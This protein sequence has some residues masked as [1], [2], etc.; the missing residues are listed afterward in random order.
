VASSSSQ[1]LTV[2]TSTNTLPSF[3]SLSINPANTLFN[4]LEHDIG[5]MTD[6]E[7]QALMRSTPPSGGSVHGSNVSMEAL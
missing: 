2:S 4:P 3:S 1:D 5:D 6:A 7:F